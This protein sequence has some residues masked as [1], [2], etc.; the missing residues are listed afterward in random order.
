VAQI[1]TEIE[2]RATW[3]V[4]KKSNAG[5]FD[6]NEDSESIRTGEV[7]SI[8]YGKTRSQQV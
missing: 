8:A 1:Y 7:K 2:A 3:G 6:S 4:F 5:F